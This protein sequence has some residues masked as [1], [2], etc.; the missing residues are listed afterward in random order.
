MGITVATVLTMLYCMPLIIMPLQAPISD[1]VLPFDTCVLLEH[2]A[3]YCITQYSEH[4][5]ALS[6]YLKFNSKITVKI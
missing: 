5:C 1:S 4:S 3:H 2:L 6:K